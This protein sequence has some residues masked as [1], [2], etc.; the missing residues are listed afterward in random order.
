MHHEV[1]RYNECNIKQEIEPNKKLGIVITWN[2]TDIYI[3]SNG[4][5]IS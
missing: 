5:D 1:M 2:E 3:Y 4:C